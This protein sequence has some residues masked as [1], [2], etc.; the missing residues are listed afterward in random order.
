[1]KEQLEKIIELLTDIREMLAPPI[2]VDPSKLDISRLKIE[3]G[4]L[5]IEAPEE[6]KCGFLNGNHTRWMID[7]QEMHKV[8]FCGMCQAKQVEGKIV[9]CPNRLSGVS[10]SSTPTTDV[11]DKGRQD[12]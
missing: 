11:H 2:L 3:P 12:T 9:E 4:V 6:I 5:Y 7:N 8:R 10:V 1:M